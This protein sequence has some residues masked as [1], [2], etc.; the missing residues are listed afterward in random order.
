M[1]E[2]LKLFSLRDI[3][4]HMAN[5]LILF[6]A[7]RFLVYKPVRAFMNARTERVQASL[8]EASAKQAEADRALSDAEKRLEAAQAEAVK[9]QADGA[10]HAQLSG[11]E[12]IEAAKRQ[13]AEIVDRAGR[14]A[15]AQRQSAQAD[16]QA[17]ALSMAVEIAEKMIGRELSEKDNDALARE[18]LT[19]V[20]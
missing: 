10:R 5:T 14:E 6:V 13:A 19:K 18:F 9:V 12:L 8:N 3:L 15:D 16:V 11:E 17:Q 20:G 7:V 1:G 2:F 4:L